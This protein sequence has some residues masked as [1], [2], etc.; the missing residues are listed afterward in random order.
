M[1]TSL[2]V[3]T[4]LGLGLE[5]KQLTFLQCSVRGVIVFAA[6]LVMVRLSSKRSLAEKTAFDAALIVIIASVLA[7]AINGSAPFFPTLGVGF[8][9]VLLHRLLSLA[10]YYSH[11]LGIVV[12]GAPAVLVQNGRLQHKNMLWN[13]IS[14]HDLEEDMRLEA[15]IEDVSKIKVARVERSGD[16]SFIKAD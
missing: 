11:T 12:K 14:E 16:I 9:L 7:R 3:N 5:A 8:V 10:A 2:S 4:L 6:T 13:H 15:A 1:N